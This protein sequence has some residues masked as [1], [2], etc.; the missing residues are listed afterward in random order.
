MSYLQIVVLALIQGM[1]ELLPV[2][3]TAHV[4]LAE[5][6]MG[7]DPS[8][9]ELTFLLVMLHTGT[10]FAVLFYFW[11]R[12]RPLLFPSASSPGSSGAP[13]SR[14]HFV[15]MILLATAAIAGRWST[16]SLGAI[17]GGQAVVGASG[18]TGPAAFVVSSWCAAVAIAL[19]GAKHRSSAVAAG[20]TAG[21]VVAG[22]SA[23]TVSGA[24]V[25]VAGALAG[26]GL[27]L[28]AWRLVPGRVRLTVAIAIAVVALAAML[29][30]PVSWSW[31]GVVDAG[32][33]TAT[34]TRV[35]AAAAFV[36][37]T[38]RLVGSP[39]S[40]RHARQSET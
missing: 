29:A 1:A 38:G 15:A 7:Q 14:F 28:L 4:I 35:I 23:V 25:R 8:S 24:A 19:A 22:P 33:V 20:I 36:V 37:V 5:R 40:P 13:A 18:W 9:P 2:S 11:P 31:T 39:A 21:L 32:R 26:V 34:M 16:S 6:L 3:S 27:A 17:A 10:M 30:G 12:W